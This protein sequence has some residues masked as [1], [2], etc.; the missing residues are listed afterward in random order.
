M[1]LILEVIGA[2]PEELFGEL[3]LATGALRRLQGPSLHR[4]RLRSYRTS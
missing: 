4:S 1:L 2:E 3:V